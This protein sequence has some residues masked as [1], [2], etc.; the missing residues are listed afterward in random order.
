[1]RLGAKTHKG[2]IRGK[3]RHV[4]MLQGL[5]GKVG[6]VALGGA[7]VLDYIEEW[8]GQGEVRRVGRRGF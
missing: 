5:T 7:E 1:M 3:I 6:T 4:T 2:L 8:T